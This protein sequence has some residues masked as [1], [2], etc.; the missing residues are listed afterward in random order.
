MRMMKRRLG[1]GF[2][3][4]AAA[5]CILSGSISA[6]Q[7]ALVT[8]S[9][10]GS[11]DNPSSPL[12][13]SG[14]FQLD[15]GTV[16]NG[17]VYNGAVTGFTLKFG[18][19][20]AAIY[21]SSFIPGANA[22]TISQNVPLGFDRWALVSAATGGPIGVATPFSF[23]LRLDQKGGGL[24][25]NFQ[26][27]PSL[28]DLNGGSARWRLFF[29]DVDGNPSAY[30]GSISTLTAVPLPAAVLLFGAGLI[31]LVGL[32]AGGLRNLRRTQA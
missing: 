6:A 13:V 24:N 32:G 18:P 28:G 26:A 11:L 2:I 14:S 29:E 7:A 21:E 31:S 19:V 1:R 25:P 30:R 10:T 15:N 3:L 22:V 23:D 20:G 5:V 8:Y 17:G 12:L 9:F 16:G 4:S 27:P